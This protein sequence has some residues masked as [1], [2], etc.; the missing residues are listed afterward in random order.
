M[1][2]ISEDDIC[3][4]VA[5][6]KRMPQDFSDI[7]NSGK[8]NPENMNMITKDTYFGMFILFR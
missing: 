1:S 5:S 2:D 8:I 3:K 4:T 6:N 7:L